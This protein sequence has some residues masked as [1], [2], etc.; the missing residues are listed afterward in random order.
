[1]KLFKVIA[2]TMSLLL[3]GACQNTTPPQ[4]TSQN[5]VKLGVLQLVE[6]PALDD[7]Y[8]GIKDELQKQGIQATYDF[9]NAQGDQSNLMTMS[10]KVVSGKPDI[11]VGITTPATLALRN[12]TTQIPIVMAGITYP[13]D[14]GLVDSESKPNGNVTGVSDRISIKKQ[15]ELMKQVLPNLKVVGVLYSLNEDNSVKQVEETKIAAQELG[16]ELKLGGVVSQNDVQ[17]T[18]ETI[19]GQV[20]AIFVPIDNTIAS[21]M[22]IVTQVTDSKQIAVFPSAS[23]M[24]KD[25]GLMGYG[26]DQYEIGVKT[27]K[28]II[29]VLKG[30]KPENTPVQLMDDA[31][32][33]INLE[34]AKQLN[35]TIPENIL[36]DAITQ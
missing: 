12:Q 18:T 11:L 6:H 5:Q 7:I 26:I 34:K 22:S 2:T 35:I 3:L 33:Y 8:K 36:K 25:G 9:Y 19:A 24:V 31:K 16:I 28:M 29:S 32:V 21:A 14:A 23:T 30:E 27:A 4:T 13:V 17:L 20:D 15:L 10:E 1:M